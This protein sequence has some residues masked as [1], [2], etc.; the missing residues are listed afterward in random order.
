MP[1]LEMCSRRILR[2]CLSSRDDRP[3]SFLNRPWSVFGGLVAVLLPI[4]IVAFGRPDPAPAWAPPDTPTT[5]A[6]DFVLNTIDNETFHLRDYRG[7]VVV[8]NFWA[9]WCP[10][11]RREIPDLVA[12]QKELGDQ[13][14]QIVGVALERDAG[15]KAVRSF[16]EKMDINYPVGLGD[17]SIAQRY[18]GVRSLPTTFVIG[19]EGN[20]RGQIPGLVTEE[21]LRPGLEKLL[22]GASP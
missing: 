2:C 9:T 21:R 20:I 4:L 11:C 8:L 10:P 7:K 14:L 19:P 16:A 15:V 18:G 6:P 13:G 17:G 1:P 22:E 12:L 5:D 3:M